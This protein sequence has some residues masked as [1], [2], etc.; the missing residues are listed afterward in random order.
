MARPLVAPAE[1]ANRVDGGREGHALAVARLDAALRRGVVGLRPPLR[2]QAG[3]IDACRSWCSTGSPRRSGPGTSAGC[4]PSRPGRGGRRT[5]WPLDARLVAAIGRP[6]APSG[7]TPS[8]CTPTIRPCVPSSV[9]RVSFSVN[10]RQPE[11]HGDHRL[12]RL[13]LAVEVR[14]PGRAAPQ[15]T[16]ARA[17]GSA[18]ASQVCRCS[19]VS[20]KQVCRSRSIGSLSVPGY[21][22]GDAP[23]G[24]GVEDTRSAARS[25]SRS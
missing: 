23:R 24:V 3:G 10:S 19:L 6:E 17:A 5:T 9:I 25:R 7:P 14:R 2:P 11:G 16:S 20:P 4:P 21:L 13:A 22:V 15:S 12:A 1:R 18:A 8:G